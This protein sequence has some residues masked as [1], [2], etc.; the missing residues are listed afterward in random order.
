[1]GVPGQNALAGPMGKDKAISLFETKLKDKTMKGEY[2][3]IEIS[4]DNEEEEKTALVKKPSK[5]LKIS[6]KVDIISFNY[7]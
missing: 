7:Y 4:Y 5:Q 3:K 6:G 1:M 2:T